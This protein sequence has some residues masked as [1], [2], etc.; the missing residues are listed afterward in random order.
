MMHCLGV[1]IFPFDFSRVFE[2]Q[3]LICDSAVQPT[4]TQPS[5]VKL[6]TRD[7][8]WKNLPQIVLCQTSLLSTLPTIPAKHIL[9]LAAVHWNI[10]ALLHFSSSAKDGLYLAL[11]IVLHLMWNKKGRDFLGTYKTILPLI[12]FSICASWNLTDKEACLIRISWTTTKMSLR[13]GT[14]AF[15]H[16]S[17]Q[18]NKNV[19]KEY[20]FAVRSVDCFILFA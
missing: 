17:S 5:L 19:I 11:G 8:V 16:D 12:T 18:P 14:F 10:S 4:P 13:G 7:I 1:F 3:L 6:A 2:G 20:N 15:I 9:L